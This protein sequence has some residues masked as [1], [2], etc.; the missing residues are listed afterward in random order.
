MIA[1]STIATAHA[2][3]AP[4]D[5]GSGPRDV[6]ASI[7]DGSGTPGPSYDEPVTIPSVGPAPEKPGPGATQ[8]EWDDYNAAV[9]EHD[10]Q[11]NAR[12]QAQA[13]EAARIAAKAYAECLARNHDND[14]EVC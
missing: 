14:T 6:G 5:D 8:D 7:D 10:R 13:L 2:E 12:A 3:P 4:I 1:A 11:V 9:A